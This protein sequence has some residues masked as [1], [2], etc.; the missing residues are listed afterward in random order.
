MQSDCLFWDNDEAVEGC[1]LGPTG[2]VTDLLLNVHYRKW[3]CFLC[4]SFICNVSVCGPIP[5]IFVPE[6]PNIVFPF[7]I[8]RASSLPVRQ[9]PDHKIYHETFGECKPLISRN[10]L[11]FGEV[12]KRYAVILEYKEHSNN[13]SLFFSTESDTASLITRFRDVFQKLLEIS[14]MERN[15]KLVYLKISPA[16][17]ST[18]RV[19]FELLEKSDKMELV[20]SNI[21]HEFKLQNLVFHSHS[22]ILTGFRGL[23]KFFINTSIVRKML[24]AEN[25]T[26]STN[27]TE[28]YANNSAFIM[29]T[30]QLYQPQEYFLSKNKQL[31]ALCKDYWP[32]NCSYYAEITDQSKWSI[33]ENGSVH[34]KTTKASWLHY[35][36]Y[37]IV[38]G[39]LRFCSKYPKAVLS[40]T[41]IHIIILSYANTL[42][43]LL[44][45]ISLIALLVVY[46]L[47]SPLR[48]LPG[49]NLMLFSAVLALS[50]IMWLLVDNKI[51]FLSSTPCG[52]KAFIMQYFFIA[53][54]SCSTSIAFHSSL[55][56]R[57]IAKGKFTHSSE[58]RFFFY[59][60]Y[61]LGLPFPFLLT[62]WVLYHYAILTVTEYYYSRHDCWFKHGISLYIACYIPAF[63][64]L[65]LNIVLF[66]KTTMFLGH[67]T[68]ERRKLAEKTGAPTRIQIGI[69]L[70]L[71][72]VMGITWLFAVFLVIF[73]DVIVFQYLY[74]FFTSLQGFYI[75]LSFLF[76]DNVKKIIARK[77]AG[78][79]RKGNSSTV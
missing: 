9:C 20:E 67:C 70:R 74:V 8:Y 46:S 45:I 25:E 53:P 42:C 76:T 19:F 33:L 79:T 28:I 7:T 44:S 21:G 13:C 48:N 47:F 11:N 35:G 60:L 64:M 18:Y 68:K 6:H 66:F 72:S 58:K 38:D 24:C 49:K 17:N 32:G 56:F 12:L 59:A 10:D 37:A 77:K 73:P 63:T 52:V 69:Y 36:D 31:L 65:L 22:R 2:L 23:C 62:S 3:D 71:S 78:A 30:R 5:Q 75:G 51:N 55:T 41:S 34:T 43:L 54:F 1:R 57:N 40:S 4:N 39:V 14:L 16:D 27:E 61:S 26:H 50:Q 29:K 15:S